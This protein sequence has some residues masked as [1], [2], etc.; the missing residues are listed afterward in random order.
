MPLNELDELAAKYG[1][2][3]SSVAAC[4]VVREILHHCL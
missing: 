1:T 2:D 3:K 4:Q